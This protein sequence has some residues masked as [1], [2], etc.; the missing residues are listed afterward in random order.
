MTA[1]ENI[2]AFIS[3]IFYTL[4]LIPGITRV[5]LKNIYKTKFARFCLKYRRKLGLLA[6]LFGFLHGT[7]IVWDRNLN[8]LDP[9]IAVKYF[10]G[11][12][13]ITIFSLLAITSND[14][15]VRKLKKNWKR[16]HKLTF[17]AL[18]VLPWHVLDKMSGGWSV[19]TALI[20]VILTL[21]IYYVTKGFITEQ[22]KNK[23]K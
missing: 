9:N 8:L 18:L 14:W 23:I 19:F 3:V 11:I 5:S 21:L 12:V 17:L 2:L 1:I 10:Q 15:S 20:L 16:L 4:T 6:W 22:L 7:Y 13:L